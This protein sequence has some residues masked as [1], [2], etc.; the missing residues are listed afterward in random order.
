MNKLWLTIPLLMFISHRLCASD[1][2]CQQHDT[3]AVNF[4][5]TTGQVHTLD[6]AASDSIGIV[7]RM[8]A[9]AF[10][11]KSYLVISCRCNKTYIPLTL[12]VT[13]NFLELFENLSHEGEY[14]IV[15][16]YPL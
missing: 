16:P 5:S 14:L 8:V 2:I 11:W 13:Y 1:I 12:D 3:S 6:I 4:K 9:R 10:D 15:T 7:Y